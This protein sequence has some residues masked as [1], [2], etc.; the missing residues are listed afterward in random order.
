MSQLFTRLLLATEHTEFDA[1]AEAVAISMAQRCQLPLAMVLPLVS[2]PEFEALAPDIALRAEQEAAVKIAEIR[3][4]AQAQG[5]AIDLR[6]R[7]GEEPYQ[8][9]LAE[10]RERD[11]ELIIVRRRGKRG[12]LANLLVGEMVSKVLAHAPCHVLFAPRDAH[13]WN[14][15]VLVA[16]EPGELGLRLVK[17]AAAIAAECSLPLH[18]VYVTASETKSTAIADFLVEAQAAALQLGVSLK[19]ELRHGK[20]YTE[21]LAAASGSQVDLLVIGS[22]GDSNIGRAMIGGVAQKVIGLSEKP[23]LALNLIRKPGDNA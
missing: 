19:I 5:V 2:N 10:A 15:G 13:M 14:Q 7:R 21:I 6:V 12:F 8:E 9:I 22:R 1:G 16:A 4:K 11:T 17:T 18:L 23:V 3:A 20:A